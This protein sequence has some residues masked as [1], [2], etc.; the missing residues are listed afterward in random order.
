MVSYETC[1]AGGTHDFGNST[2]DEMVN[3]EIRVSYTCGKCGIV[4]KTE[5]LTKQDEVEYEDNNRERCY[6]T[7]EYHDWHHGNGREHSASDQYFKDTCK[8]C[9]KTRK[10]WY[11]HSY[12]IYTDSNG[13]EL[14][15]DSA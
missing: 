13:H 2:S 8:K 3:D 4:S 12:T 15:R 10:T 1:G 7:D 11:C 9:D 14:H 6:N 5:M